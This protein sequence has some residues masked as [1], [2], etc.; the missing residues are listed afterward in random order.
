MRPEL[1][2]LA[3]GAIAVAG[4]AIAEKKWPDNVGSVVIGTVVLVVVA[5]ATTD[6]KIAS[7][8]RAIGLLLVMTTIMAA[9]K[10]AN[11]SKVKKNG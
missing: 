3:A 8:V 4:G 1:P 2:F 5:S 10:R 9:V 6:T 11:E 7:L